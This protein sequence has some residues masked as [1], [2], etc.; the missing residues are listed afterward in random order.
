MTARTVG[1]LVLLCACAK[2]VD[3]AVVT[4]AT[5]SRADVGT[6]I[7]A[8]TYGDTVIVPAGNCT[9]TSML[10]IT[11]AITLQGAGIDSTTVISAVGASNWVLQYTPDATSRANDESFRITGFTFNM[12]NAS[13][14]VRVIQGSDT[15]VMHNL[16]I[17]GNKFTNT[18][19]D[20][21]LTLPCLR[22]GDFS[23]TRGQ[24]YG[25]VYNN[26]FVNCA[27]AAQSYGDDVYSWD[28]HTFAYGTADNLYFEDNT[29]SG[30]SAFH[31]GGLGGRYASRFNAYQFTAG[32]FQVLWDIH[33]NQSGQVYATM[34]CEIYRNTV[35]LARTTT[36]IDHRGGSCMF[37]QNTLTGT[38][39]SWQVR[40]EYADSIDPTVNP[41]PQHVS[42]SYYFLNT[43][44]GANSGVT[45]LSDCCG[46]LA[47]N[48]SFWNYTSSFNGTVGIG[49]G[50]LAARPSSCTAGVGYWAADQGSWNAKGA[51][52]VLYKCTSAN[53]WTLYY[54]PYPYPHPLR[55]GITQPPTPPTNLRIIR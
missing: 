5:C 34:G 51:S 49:S 36:I 21:S 48:A 14:G 8:S 37:F 29:F 18:T 24:V 16:Q 33:G 7:T 42:N 41:Q 19:G 53:T 2:T 30:N 25:V 23:G 55:A 28:N 17:Y 20:T 39:G 15:V 45:L 40:E 44:N 54:K 43:I 22:T 35:S 32:A 47:E 10:T 13:G 1:F 9:W 11:K 52:G 3:A 38:N 50:P 4:A 27:S 46:V 6:A 31:Y 26:Q 12:N